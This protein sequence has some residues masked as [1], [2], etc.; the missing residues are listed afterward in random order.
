MDS[1]KRNR[2][3]IGGKQKT[4]RPKQQK[5]KRE[6]PNSDSLLLFFFSLGKPGQKG[7]RVE[8]KCSKRHRKSQAAK[9]VVNVLGVS[10]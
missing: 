10:F 4:E 5:E 1:T 2:R 6:N 9:S 7:Q 3:F 8:G